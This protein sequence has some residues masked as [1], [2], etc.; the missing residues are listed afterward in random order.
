MANSFLLPEVVAAAA[1]GLLNR[2]LVLP[3]FCTRYGAADFAGAKDDTV[4]VRVYA[5]QTAQTRT[6]RAAG[7]LTADD[8]TEASVAVALDTHVYKLAN[9]SDED[10]TLSIEDFAAQV[11]APQVLAVAEGM[12]DVIATALAAADPMADAVDFAEGTD[13]PYDVAVDLRKALN[14]LN[15]PRSNRVLI[16]G[17]DVEA[18]FLKSDR[19]ADANTSGTDDALREAI[20]GRIAGFTVVGSNAIAS[21]AYYAMHQSAIAFAS[22]APAIPEGATFG[23][24]VT[25][26][27][28]G[29]RWLRDYDPT[30]VRD[31]S[32]V[33]A[34]VGATSVEEDDNASGVANYRLATGTFTAAGS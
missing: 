20:I 34:F 13:D 24:G 26:E 28:L 15:V 33:D 10:L 29:L 31:R 17:S 32:L 2:E 23:Q 3:R 4:N 11:L 12:E 7:A 21:D 6:M 8:L 25:H 1:V 22:V 27:G 19:I 9:I 14:E 16:L 5:S 30:N 18:A